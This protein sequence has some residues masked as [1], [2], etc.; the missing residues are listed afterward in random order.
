MAVVL[1]AKDHGFR[2]LLLVNRLRNRARRLAPSSVRSSA[3]YS[4]LEVLFASFLLLVVAVS[5]I[6][7]FTRALQSN[8]IGARASSQANFVSAN[9]EALNEKL[10]D[11]ED[12]DLTGGDFVAI[13]PQYWWLGASEGN[14]T[15]GDEQ[16]KTTDADGGLILWQRSLEVRKYSVSDILPTV[17]IDGTDIT[18]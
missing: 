15:L 3:G 14:D 5:I 12:Y 17:S 9:L 18:G 2:N 4:L 11:H 8:L 7:M 10:I 16:W 13:S 6:P 1:M